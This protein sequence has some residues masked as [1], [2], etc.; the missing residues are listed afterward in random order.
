MSTAVEVPVQV[1]V[2]VSPD[3]VSNV[4]NVD[5]VVRVPEVCVIL[6]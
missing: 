2:C 4:L 5:V 6:D 3:P 1:C